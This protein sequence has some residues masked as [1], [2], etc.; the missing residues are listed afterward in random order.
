MNSAPSNGAG[1]AGLTIG[2]LAALLCLVPVLG[3]LIGVTAATLGCIGLHQC[4]EGQATNSTA[5]KWAIGLGVVG[6]LPSALL[7]LLIAS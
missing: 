3:F 1:T 7:V 5:C 2:V 6:M 4:G